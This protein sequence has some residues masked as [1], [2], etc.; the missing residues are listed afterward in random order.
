M[1]RAA[2]TLHRMLPCT[3]VSVPA[4]ITWTVYEPKNKLSSISC[5]SHLS[6]YFLL[7]IFLQE[8]ALLRSAERTATV[9]IREDA[10]LLAVDRETFVDVC[11]EMLDQE[12]K[13]KVAFCR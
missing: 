12:L 9:V 6:H 4:K 10:E 13:V 5:Q 3:P 8:V 7:K 2:K 11:P 1:E